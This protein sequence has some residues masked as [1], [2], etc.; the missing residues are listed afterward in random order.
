M[1][2]TFTLGAGLTI[3][4]GPGAALSLLLAA[5]G[6]NL[7]WGIIDGVLYVL[8]ALSNRARR[9]RFVLAV[10]AARDE[11][12]AA[13]LIRSEV[14]DRLD[15]LASPAARAALAA[16]VQALLRSEAGAATAVAAVNASRVTRDDLLGALAI[17]WLEVLACIPAIIPFIVLSH[18]HLLALRVSNGLLLV[19]LFIVGQQW[20]RYAGLNRWLIGLLLAGL[21]LL[22]VGVAIL[23]GG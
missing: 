9:L 18:D 13:A 11:A 19:M 16:D 5:I 4:D 21:G 23:L 7:A 15:T 8:T 6:C 22:L 3:E 12:A 10:H 20:A 1:V 2:L 17:F 14:D